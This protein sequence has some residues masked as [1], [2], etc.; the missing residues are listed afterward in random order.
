[1]EEKENTESTSMESL[2]KLY[3]R[4]HKKSG[5][6]YRCTEAKWRRQ[7]PRGN[8]PETHSSVPL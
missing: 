6:V 5:S 7:R 8:K 4:R 3:K 2:K 1:M